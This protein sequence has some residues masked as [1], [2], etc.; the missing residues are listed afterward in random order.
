LEAASAFGEFADIFARRNVSRILDLV[1]QFLAVM[2]ALPP[3]IFLW[4]LN[5][6]IGSSRDICDIVDDVIR[7]IL[8]FASKSLIDTPEVIE[9]IVSLIIGRLELR[10]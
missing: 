10:R 5:G 2:P 3:D 4:S 9:C 1:H 8:K 7:T 6:L